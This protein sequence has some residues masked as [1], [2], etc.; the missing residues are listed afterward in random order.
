MENNVFLSTPSELAIARKQCFTEYLEQMQE[1]KEEKRQF[2]ERRLTEGEAVM[3]FFFQKKG[4]PGPDGYPVYIALHGG[5]HSETPDMNDSQ[6]RHQHVYYFDS[7]SDGICIAPRGVRDTWNTH[8]NEESYPLYDRLIADLAAYEQIDMNRVYLLGFSAGGDGVYGITPYM[9][10]RFAAANMSAGHPNFVNLSNLYNLPLEL[11]VG[12]K[13]DAFDRARTTAGY[14]IYLDRLQRSCHGGYVHRV[15]IHSGK[16]HNFKDNDPAR[17]PQTVLTDYRAWR[18]R[19]NESV[20][21]TNTNAVDYVSSFVRR[22]LPQRVVWSLEQRANFRSVHSHYWLW[23]DPSVR[24]GRAVV[25]YWK[26]NN[27]IT[28]EELTA[29]GRVFALVNEEMLDIFSPITVYYP[30]HTQVVRV[31]P[32]WRTLRETTK[33]RGDRNYQFCAKIELEL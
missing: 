7:V 23:A 19:G 12:Q 33:E 25:S 14:G 27:S 28:V 26:E 3:R 4:K 24:V 30:D 11:Q 20:C 22:P 10:D 21:Q 2:E 31:K 8:F 1:N 15:L 13:D 9:A 6:W 18:E 17:T 32:E 29:N 5:G 16:P